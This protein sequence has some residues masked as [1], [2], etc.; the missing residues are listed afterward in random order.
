MIKKVEL[1]RRLEHE[2]A[3]LEAMLAPLTPDQMVESAVVG[4]WSVK[5]VLAYFIAHLVE[6]S[7]LAQSE[8]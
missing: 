4:G 7:H 6:R 8:G 1:L 2:R 3:R 5:D